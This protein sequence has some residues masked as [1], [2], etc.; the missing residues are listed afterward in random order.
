MLG[1]ITESANFRLDQSSHGAESLDSLSFLFIY[2]AMKCWIFSKAV[3][4]GTLNGVRCED[5][6][7]QDIDIKLLIH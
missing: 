2:N 1:V 7:L 5:L 6:G 3:S 4:F